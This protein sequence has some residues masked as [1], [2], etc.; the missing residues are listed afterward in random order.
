MSHVNASQGLDSWLL[1]RP[2]EEFVELRKNIFGDTAVLIESP[3]S[4]VE[5][6]DSKHKTVL[7][8]GEAASDPT[9]L[10]VIRG[11]IGRKPRLLDFR[12]NSTWWCD[13]SCPVFKLA[14]VEEPE[15][16]AAR[17][18]APSKKLDVVV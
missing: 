18:A 7:L 3:F 13:D 8:A 16:A 1:S 11:V 9:Y 10:E 17:G 14:A 4:P 6:G 5:D 15:F 12:N 2:T